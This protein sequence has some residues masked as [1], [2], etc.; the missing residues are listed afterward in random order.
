MYEE[1]ILLRFKKSEKYCDYYDFLV[2]TGENAG[3]LY[4][5]VK[6]TN[7]YCNSIRINSVSISR[8]I[9]DSVE[10][11]CNEDDYTKCKTVKLCDLVKDF[12]KK[13][14][15]KKLEVEKDLKI[16]TEIKTKRETIQRKCW[17]EIDKC[18]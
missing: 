10:L 3:M 13:N 15:E 9:R 17:E 2:L 5:N 1:A 8:Y 7:G 12:D 6:V 4:K 16:K 18:Y 11:M 14:N